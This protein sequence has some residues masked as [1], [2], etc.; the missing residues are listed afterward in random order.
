MWC[1]LVWLFTEFE[2]P[3]LS[4]LY[5]ASNKKPR[6]MPGFFIGFKN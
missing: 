6:Q 2:P 4:T 1:F 5:L 3:T